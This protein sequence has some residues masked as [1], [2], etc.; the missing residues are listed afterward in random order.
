MGCLASCQMT[1]D[2]KETLD[3]RFQ[4]LRE[5]PILLNFDNF[6]TMFYPRV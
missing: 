1:L 6:S 5:K 3:F 2:F 4:N